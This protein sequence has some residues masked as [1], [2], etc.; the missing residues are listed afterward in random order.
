MI[1]IPHPVRRGK[2]DPHDL[3]HLHKKQYRPGL[4]ESFSPLGDYPP[5][6]VCDNGNHHIWLTDNP[7]QVTCPQCLE[8]RTQILQAT[9]VPQCPNLNDRSLFDPRNDSRYVDENS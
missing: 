5:A 8:K 4:R 1:E 2:P 6:I 3:I 9:T 7:R